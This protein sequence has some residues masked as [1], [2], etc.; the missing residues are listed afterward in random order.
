MLLSFLPRAIPPCVAAHAMRH[1]GCLSK[2][3]FFCT[4]FS[5]EVTLVS[6]YSLRCCPFAG[7]DT[8]FRSV[9][10]RTFLSASAGHPLVKNG[11]DTKITKGQLSLPPLH[12]HNNP[13]KCKILVVFYKLE[14]VNNGAI[15]KQKGG[16]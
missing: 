16:E 3:L 7:T 4:S 9:T 6:I 13:L 5:S 1:Q 11:H 2:Q 14:M 15:S 8:L 12:S 10:G